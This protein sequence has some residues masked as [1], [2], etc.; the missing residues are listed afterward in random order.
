MRIYYLCPV[1]PARAR[2][3]LARCT[4]AASTAQGERASGE[5]GRV[6]FPQNRRI[7]LDAAIDPLP[8]LALFPA[9]YVARPRPTAR[10]GRL[11]IRIGLLSRRK[12]EG[13]L[14]HP[15]NCEFLPLSFSWAVGMA[16]S[17]MISLTCTYLN[18]LKPAAASA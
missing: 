1:R 15:Q 4:A 2:A 13:R 6:I 12:V 16:R 7:N 5:I 10:R 9:F 8:P 18:I 14:S 17:K 3:R 11:S